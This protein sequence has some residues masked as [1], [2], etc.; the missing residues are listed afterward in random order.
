M[1]KNPETLVSKMVENV[2]LPRY[3]YCYQRIDSNGHTLDIL[4]T[5]KIWFSRPQDFND[6]FDCKV[7]PTEIST[8]FVVSRA[9]ES[10]FSRAFTRETL[11]K[12][13]SNEEA[14]KY[15]QKAIDKVMGD[16]GIK[17]FTPYPDNLL[18]W[19]HYADNHKGICFE[20]DVLEDPDFFVFP[21][22]V[23]YEEKYPKIDFSN[24]Q[25]TTKIYST[26][27][28]D[29]KYED[30]I[31]VLKHK[32]GLHSF[33]PKMIKS[34][35]FGCRISDKDKNEILHIISADEE[36]RHIELKTAIPSNYDY[37]LNIQSYIP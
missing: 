32:Y 25:D 33:N 11:R 31:R 3:L 35:I 7:Y 27:S 20:F 9:P 16:K 37:Q 26:K 21:V 23:K 10:A 34:V 17:C 13:L 24:V 22:W 15:I 5:K 2:Q 30:E 28:M 6:P 19:S 18:M 8:D 4:R 1:K 14:I 36:L 12:N 29:W